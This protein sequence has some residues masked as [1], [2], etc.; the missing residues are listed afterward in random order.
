MLRRILRRAVYRRE[1]LLLYVYCPATQGEGKRDPAIECFDAAHR[2]P[3]TVQEQIRRAGGRLGYWLMAHRMKRDGAR[4]LVLREE[5]RLRAYGWIQGWRSFRRLLWLAPGA[6]CLGFYWTAPA[7]RGRGLYGRLLKHSIAVCEERNRLPLIIFTSPNNMRSQR[8]IEKAG[9]LRLGE[10]ELQSW[11]G[12]LVSR[13]RTIREEHSLEQAL[14]I[15]RGCPPVKKGAADIS[16]PIIA[17][18]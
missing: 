13:H 6:R 8:G 7:D 4:L 15:F 10:Y 9:F 14:E 5:N 17:S 2:P 16:G 18:S 11:F 1:R 3:A 12:G